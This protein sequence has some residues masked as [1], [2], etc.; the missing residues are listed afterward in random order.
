MTRLEIILFLKA[1]I[2]CGNIKG[3]G[4]RWWVRKSGYFGRKKS[5]DPDLSR[6]NARDRKIPLK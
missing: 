1:A 3:R 5:L 6:Q 4:T 2:H